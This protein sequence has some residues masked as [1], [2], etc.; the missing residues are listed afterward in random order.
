MRTL[1]TKNMALTGMFIAL[2]LVLPFATGQIPE[3]GSKLL[4]MHIPVLIC[5]FI[6]GWPYGL[7]VGLITPILRSVIFGMPPLFPTAVAMT[8]EL[9]AYGFLA[10]FIYKMLPKK[11]FMIY[12]SLLM[13]MIGGRIVWGVVSYIL[14]GASGTSFA[15]NTFIAGAFVEALPGIILQIVLIPPIVIALK[16]AKITAYA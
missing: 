8:F 9:A 2:G 13:A 15:M 12:F 11:N 5:G 10:G 1:S 14:Y 16:K 3:I 7:T 4:P 6:C